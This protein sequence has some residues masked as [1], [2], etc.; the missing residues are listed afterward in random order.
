MEPMPSV[1]R[2]P[3]HS[4]RRAKQHSVCSVLGLQVVDTVVAAAVPAAIQALCAVL[5]ALCAVLQVAVCR[6]ASVP[7][8][9]SA[10]VFKQ[11]ALVGGACK[12]L[13]YTLV[14]CCLQE[15]CSGAG[16]FTS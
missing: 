5:Q 4:A 8:L 2:P 6:T 3:G 10:V 14:N 12:N 7:I 13:L 16:S 15:V 1:T 9:E 11:L